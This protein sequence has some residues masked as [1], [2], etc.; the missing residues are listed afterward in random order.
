MIQ[1]NMFKACFDQSFFKT[2]SFSLLIY[3]GLYCEFDQILFQSY[4]TGTNM[5]LIL[6]NDY[7]CKHGYIDKNH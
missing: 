2:C 6:K 7:R 4:T 1:L 5:N 3:Q